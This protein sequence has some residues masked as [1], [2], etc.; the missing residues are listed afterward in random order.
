MTNQTTSPVPSSSSPP[1][2]W[3]MPAS[4]LEKLFRQNP[5]NPDILCNLGHLNANYIMYQGTV[6]G[7]N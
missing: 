1:D 6:R 3:T 5:D 4:A 2:A 7:H